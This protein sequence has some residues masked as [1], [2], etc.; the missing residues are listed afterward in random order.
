LKIILSFI[1][2]EDILKRIK[3]NC[4]FLI[5][6]DLSNNNITDK[7]ALLLVDA[8]KENNT[9]K[10]INLCRNPLGDIGRKA[11]MEE[12]KDRGI[13]ISFVKNFIAFGDKH[14]IYHIYKDL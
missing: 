10:K 6:L 1:L 12:I 13:E 11:L 2:M 4:K 3:S 14:C 7:V 5:E 9:I 8:L